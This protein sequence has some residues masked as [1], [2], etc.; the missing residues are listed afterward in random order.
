M[1][2][3]RTAIEYVAC[4][5]FSMALR[6]AYRE[7]VIF[8]MSEK[9]VEP[10]VARLRSSKEV[11]QVLEDLGLEAN[12]AVGSHTYRQNFLLWEKLSQHIEASGKPLPP[13]KAIL[14]AAVDAWNK[15]KGGVD[16]VSRILANVK[17]CHSRI[18]LHGR[19][20]LRFFQTLLMNAHLSLRLD[21]VTRAIP[22]QTRWKDYFG[23]F[24][25]YKT[26]LNSIRSYESFLMLVHKKWNQLRLVPDLQMQPSEEESDCQSKRLPQGGRK[27]AYKAVGSDEWKT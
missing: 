1:E 14:P 24:R 27:N 12:W 26:R 17:D 18:G 11:E 15:F 13:S 20:N 22:P 2:A 7:S 23:S 3:T 6:N 5:E 10:I 19:L 9:Y 8:P 25:K 16:I 21:E 4:V